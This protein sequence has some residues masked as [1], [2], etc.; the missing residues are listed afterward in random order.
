VSLS[1]TWDNFM[2]LVVCEGAGLILDVS[3]SQRYVMPDYCGPI[4]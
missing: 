4:I 1:L 3:V 2:P